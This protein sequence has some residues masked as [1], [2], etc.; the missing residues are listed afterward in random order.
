MKDRCDEALKA[1]DEFLRM[2]SD[3]EE[4]VRAV[5]Q[6][7]KALETDQK[8]LQSAIDTKL[9]EEGARMRLDELLDSGS[10]KTPEGDGGDNDSGFGNDEGDIGGDE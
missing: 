9:V 7:K 10:L 1:A 2:H 3:N 6:A 8:L 4:A 5:K